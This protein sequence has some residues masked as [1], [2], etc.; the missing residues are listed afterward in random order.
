MAVD[1]FIDRVCP[2]FRLA[3]F[4]EDLW[5]LVCST[6]PL[7]LFATRRLPAQSKAISSELAR[8]GEVM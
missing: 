7:A 1:Q 2:S 8:L 5:A 6:A 4:L 3:S